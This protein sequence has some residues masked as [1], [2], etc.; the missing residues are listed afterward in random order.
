MKKFSLKRELLTGFIIFSVGLVITLCTGFAA[1]WNFELVYTE[2]EIICSGEISA[3]TLDIGFGEIAIEFDEVERAKVKYTEAL[4]FPV[5]ITENSGALKVDNRR[6]HW[7]NV[8]TPFYNYTPR[9]TI[10]LPKD[11]PVALK[12]DVG[13]GK[14]TVPSAKFST[15]DLNISAGKITGGNIE[16][17]S[18]DADVSAGDVYFDSVATSVFKIEISA[19]QSVVSKLSSPKIDIDVSAGKFVTEVQGKKSDY[20]IDVDESAGSCNVKNQ[21]NVATTNTIRARVSAGTITIDFG[22]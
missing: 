1:H 17:D 22:E 13:A 16:C 5:T 14:L 19:G 7:I 3:L 15:V 20:N 8:S 10:T 6:L 21:L 12:A 11:T 9:I 2:N 18:F 4:D